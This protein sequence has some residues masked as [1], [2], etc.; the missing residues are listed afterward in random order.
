MLTGSVVMQV[1]VAALSNCYEGIQLLTFSFCI[2]FMDQ[3]R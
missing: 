2:Y 1:D 3:F